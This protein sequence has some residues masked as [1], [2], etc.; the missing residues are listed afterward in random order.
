MMHIKTLT[1]FSIMWVALNSEIAHCIE[2]DSKNKQL[3]IHIINIP[4]AS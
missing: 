2:L 4:K 3:P 1:L